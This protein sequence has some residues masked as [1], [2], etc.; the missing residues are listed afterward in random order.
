MLTSFEDSRRLTDVIFLDF[1][2]DFG[3][4]SHD[5]FINKLRKH[6]QDET[7]MR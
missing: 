2:K 4:V 5:I 6:S 1:S 3:T 7:T